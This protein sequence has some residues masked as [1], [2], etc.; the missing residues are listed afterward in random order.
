M[1]E[2]AW[3][4]PQ[5]YQSW[6]VSMPILHSMCLHSFILT[7]YIL[8][9][10]FYSAVFTLAWHIRHN[11]IFF[12]R[13]V[14]WRSIYVRLS[15]NCRSTPS[16]CDCFEKPLFVPA[17][18]LLVQGKCSD[19]ASVNTVNPRLAWEY[20]QTFLQLVEICK[21]SENCMS[22]FTP[23]LVYLFVLFWSC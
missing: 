3:V 20:I 1:W 8:F 22:S 19:V 13:S 11:S 14:L 16:E 12:F 18:L 15:G 9:L 2:L 6:P 10:F 4:I 17:R 21:K 7:P 5:R 23:F